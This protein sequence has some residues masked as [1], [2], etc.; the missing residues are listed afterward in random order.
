MRERE[1][2]MCESYLAANRPLRSV[3]PLPPALEEFSPQS[4]AFSPQLLSAKA[5]LSLSLSPSVSLPPS[6][7]HTPFLFPTLSSSLAVYLSSLLTLPLSPHRCRG[8]VSLPTL[9]VGVL[10]RPSPPRSHMGEENTHIHTQAPGRESH[11]TGALLS[12]LQ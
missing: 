12:L 9:P 11:L 8:C 2:G 5:L 7:L 3:S 4:K 6:L 10:Q 1:K